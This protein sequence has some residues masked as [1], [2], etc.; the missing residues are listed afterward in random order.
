M[1]SNSHK[2]LYGIDKFAR[3]FYCTHARLGQLR[4]D[5]H[6]ARVATRKA[7]KQEVAEHMRDEEWA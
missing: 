2:K 6:M 3:K 4:N 1:K 5:K 7:N